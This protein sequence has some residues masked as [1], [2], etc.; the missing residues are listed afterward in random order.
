MAEGWGGR[1]LS[2]ENNSRGHAML[3]EQGLPVQKATD[4]RACVLC[5]CILT[6]LSLRC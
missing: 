1:C 2:E 3:Y 5:V 6:I 4:D